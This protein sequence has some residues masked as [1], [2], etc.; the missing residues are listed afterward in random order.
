MMTYLKRLGFLL[1]GI[2]LVCALALAWIYFRRPGLPEYAAHLH[3]A[4]A[5][6]AG[7]VPAAWSGTTAVLLRDGEHAIFV[8]PFYT[9]PEGL[10]NLLLNRRIAP[11]EARIADWLARAEVKKLDAV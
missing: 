9:R 11:D 7:G 4:A 10:L 1:A 5:G 3:P 6:G 8:D 2:V